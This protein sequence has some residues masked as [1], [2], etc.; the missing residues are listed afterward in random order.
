M[1]PKNKK[2]VQ[3]L[4][5]VSSEGQTSAGQGHREVFLTSMAFQ[6]DWEERREKECTFPCMV[7]YTATAIGC[8]RIPI[9]IISEGHNDSYL[10]LNIILAKFRRSK[11]PLV[12]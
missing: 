5:H 8:S 9:A 2:Y 6:P 3:S 7:L 4:T 12:F 10:E 11:V 1:S